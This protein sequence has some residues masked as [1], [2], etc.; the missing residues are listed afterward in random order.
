MNVCSLQDFD[1]TCE[2]EKKRK[3][4]KERQR[5]RGKKKGR[6]SPVK[7][8]VALEILLAVKL[9][10]TRKINE[11]WTVKQTSTKAKTWRGGD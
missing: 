2:K 5:E 10:C 8:S 7:D 9:S 1:Y 6:V 3:K 4:R 11:Q